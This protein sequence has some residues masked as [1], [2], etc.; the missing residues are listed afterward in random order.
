MGF[1]PAWTHC[2]TDSGFEL[3]V[4]SM[5]GNPSGIPVPPPGLAADHGVDGLGRLPQ[6]VKI[7]ALPS[8]LVDCFFHLNH[9]DAF[10]FE[11]T[12]PDPLSISTQPE[13]IFIHMSAYFLSK[14]IH[15][16]EFRL[17]RLARITG[18]MIE[19]HLFFLPRVETVMGNLRRLR[20]Q[21]LDI[22]AQHAVGSKASSFR[23]SLWPRMEP[24]PCFTYSTLSPQA[25]LRTMPTLDP[26]FFVQ[27]MLA[28]YCQS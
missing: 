28:N 21:M 16:V 25:T 14:Q 11:W 17:T 9:E 3:H 15:W 4:H 19:E 23:L 2:D 10:S 1:L 20:G 24:L 7:D 8:L 5:W 22:I 12:G 27:N 6:S 26:S 13:D 18:N